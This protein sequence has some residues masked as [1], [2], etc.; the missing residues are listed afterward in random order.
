MIAIFMQKE[1][2]EKFYW[3]SR[4]YNDN[5]DRPNKVELRTS[6]MFGRKN[7]LIF[8]IKSCSSSMTFIKSW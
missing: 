7:F 8:K 6:F 2:N 1:R 5:E 4:V 3:A